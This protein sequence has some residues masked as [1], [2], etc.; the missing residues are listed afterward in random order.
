MQKGEETKETNNCYPTFFR[1][2]SQ[3]KD[4]ID[5][6]G[7]F[8][9]DQLQKIREGK[10]TEIASHWLKAAEEGQRGEDCAQLYKECF[11]DQFSRKISLQEAYTNLV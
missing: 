6:V 8:I 5:T 10:W 1:I 2:S 9:R 3:S 11:D 4:E 7:E